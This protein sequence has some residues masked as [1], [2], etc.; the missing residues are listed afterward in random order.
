MPQVRTRIRR[1]FDNLSEPWRHCYICGKYEAE[2]S[3]EGTIYGGRMHPESELILYE[4]KY[5]CVPHF[6][7]RFN[8]QFIDDYKLEIEEIDSTE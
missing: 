7:Y 3:D 6:D 4:G 2:Q 8:M 5:Y 1:H